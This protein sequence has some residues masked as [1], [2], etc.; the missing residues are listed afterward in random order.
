MFLL[1]SKWEVYIEGT[2]VYCNNL[3]MC[4]LNKS[5]LYCLRIREIYVVNLF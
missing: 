3:V 1:K 4:G 2:R 5:F